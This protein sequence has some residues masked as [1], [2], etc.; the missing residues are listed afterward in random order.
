M[1]FVDELL[2]EQQSLTAVDRFSQPHADATRPVQERYYRDLIPFHRPQEG[3]QYS[4]EVDLEA[5]SGCKACVSACHH[6]NGLDAGESWRDIG[7]LVSDHDGMVKQQ[8]VTTACH[9]CEEPACAHGC[10][11]LA[12]EKD[13]ITGI[14]RHLDDQCM[15]CR[16]CE[17]KCP[18]QVPKYNA[19]LGIVRK[20]D[21]CQSRLANGEAP[22]CVQACP[23]EAIRIRVVAREEASSEVLLPGTVSSDY[24]QPT[25]RFLNL[26]TAA[27]P[28]E[29][30]EPHPAHGHIPLVA[31]LV[32][33]PMSI[34]MTAAHVLGDQV[35]LSILIVATLCGFLGLAGSVLHLGRPSQAW[36]AVLGWRR[37]W[38][39]REIIAFNLWAGSQALYTAAAVSQ[40]LPSAVRPLGGLAV[41][42]GCLGLATS[43]MVY[44]DTRRPFWQASHTAW[45]FYGTALCAALTCSPFP[46]LAIVPMVFLIAFEAHLLISPDDPRL[47]TSRQLLRG[48][49]RPTTVFR[50]MTAV[51]FVGLVLAEM[52]RIALLVLVMSELAARSLFFRA[53]HEPKMP[54]VAL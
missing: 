24:T 43:V 1:P 26:A 38:L 23:N 39:S 29:P 3:Q 30:Q 8:V 22:A 35:N 16:Y 41:F 47:A 7:L 5:C 19:A 25:T 45:R 51:A 6:L 36:R 46:W 2:L 27:R 34:G 33:V 12:Y 54:G 14:V 44:A 52:P 18:Y 53:V 31:M 20:C 37:S 49:L 42:L 10:P 28:S 48:A 17:L 11:T 32:L 50:L 21:M 15:G 40:W 13:A 9:H 4:F